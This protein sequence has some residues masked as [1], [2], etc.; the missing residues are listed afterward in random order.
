MNAHGSH[1]QAVVRA[2]DIVKAFRHE[3]EE[4]LLADVVER[5][6]LRRTTC[7]RL[8]HSLVHGG[9]LERTA[10]GVYRCPFPPAPGRRFRLGFAAQTDS[11]FSRHVTE[12]LQRAAAKERVDLIT[13]NNRYSPKEAVRNADLLVHEHVDLVLEFQT[14]ERIAPE[15]ASKFLEARIPVIAIEIPHPGAI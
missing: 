12:S 14:Y 9:L 1:V 4:L 2:C 10:R 6:G 7:F 3:G 13:V 15:I 11:E 5:T 8:L